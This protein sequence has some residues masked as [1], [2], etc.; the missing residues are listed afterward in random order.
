LAGFL[1]ETRPS[2]PL[3]LAAVVAA[4]LVVA[5]IACA[6]PG[7]RASGEDQTRALRAD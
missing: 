2:D 4:V 5:L 6:G 7:W 1:Y 3:T